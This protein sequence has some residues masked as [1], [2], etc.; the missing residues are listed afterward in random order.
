MPSASYHV[1]PWCFPA[2]LLLL[3]G[4][5]AGQGE[6]ASAPRPVAVGRAIDTA[7]QTDACYYAARVNP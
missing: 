5:S 6:S 2:L 1:R 3:A 7:D 4:C